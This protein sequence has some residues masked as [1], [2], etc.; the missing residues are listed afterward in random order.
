MKST[1]D[2]SVL[3]FFNYCESVI[4][5]KLKIKSTLENVVI[6]AFSFYIYISNNLRTEN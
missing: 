3:S 2:L 5:S 6:F 4:I 1:E